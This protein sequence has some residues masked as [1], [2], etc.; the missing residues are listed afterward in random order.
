[1]VIRRDRRILGS[2]ADRPRLA[3]A[4]QALLVAKL[5]AADFPV[6]GSPVDFR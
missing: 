4:R 6:G 3:A 2:R 1:M 5:L